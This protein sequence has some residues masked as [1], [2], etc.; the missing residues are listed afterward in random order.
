MEENKISIEI[1]SKGW[2]TTV[3][4]SGKTFVQKHVATSTGAKGIEGDFEHENNI[5]EEVYDALNSTFSFECMQALQIVE[6]QSKN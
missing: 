2:T 6:S 4:L 3:Y 1:T 5:P